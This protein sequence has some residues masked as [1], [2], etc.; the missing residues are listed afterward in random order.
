[1]KNQLKD[2]LANDADAA[3]FNYDEEKGTLKLD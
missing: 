2:S 3:Y 1:M